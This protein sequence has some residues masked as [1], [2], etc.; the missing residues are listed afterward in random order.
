M[1]WIISAKI[2][3]VETV[4]Y[5]MLLPFPLS[6]PALLIFPSNAGRAATGAGGRNLR[7]DACLLGSTK[8]G[9]CGG[10]RKTLSEI[11]IFFIKNEEGRGWTTSSG[12]TPLS[13]FRPSYW[14][15]N[16]RDFP[17]LSNKKFQLG[18]GKRWQQL[19]GRAAV[20]APFLVN[21]AQQVR[22]LLQKRESTSDNHISA[23]QRR[24]L[25]SLKIPRSLSCEF[26]SSEFQTCGALSIPSLEPRRKPPTLR[27]LYIF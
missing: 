21:G 14:D 18:P 8:G 17:A 24:A 9:R 22:H 26:P 27:T 16:L 20:S 7:E 1:E 25:F 3:N 5:K 10:G 15:S 4:P 11:E 13:S 2:I 6:F 23:R 19:K 12:L